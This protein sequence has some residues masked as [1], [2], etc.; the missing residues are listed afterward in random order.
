[1]ITSDSNIMQKQGDFIARKLMLMET[2]LRECERLLELYKCKCNDKDRVTF[3]DFV[4]HSV[5]TDSI[6][7]GDFVDA[8]GGQLTFGSFVNAGGNKLTFGSYINTSGNSMTFSN[9]INKT[10][11]SL[12]FNNFIN[13]G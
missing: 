8:K 7:F 6:V 11:S 4:E 2:R 3:G 9:F 1:M 5:E 13:H 10:T 12:T